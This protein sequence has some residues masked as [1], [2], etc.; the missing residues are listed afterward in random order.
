MRRLALTVG[1]LA[2]I[3][4]PTVASGGSTT[5]EAF[6]AKMS[7]R[8]EVPR[9]DT[10]AR[11]TARISIVRSR[12]GGTRIV[13]RLTG[14]GL[15]G[16]PQA[17]HIHLGRPGESGGVMFPMR[18]EPFTLPE[19][20]TLRRKDFVPVG[21]VRTFTQALRAIRRGRTYTNIHTV[22]FPAGEIRGQNRPR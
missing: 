20:G 13:W 10:T 17:A 7:G 16:Q 18:G 15:T 21:N 19:R 3:A 6:Q 22:R 8:Q 4:V 2:A 12:S 9:A 5:T 1:A 14:R 11:G